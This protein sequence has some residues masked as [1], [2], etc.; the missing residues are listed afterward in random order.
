M[1]LIWAKQDSSPFQLYCIW[2]C[3]TDLQHTEVRSKP[4]IN[5][6]LICKNVLSPRP[7]LCHAYVEQYLTPREFPL[8]NLNYFQGKGSTT[9]D[10]KAESTPKVCCLSWAFVFH[11]YMQMFK[12][13][14]TRSISLNIFSCDNKETL[15]QSMGHKGPLHE[16]S[17]MIK[18]KG[19]KKKSMALFIKNIEHVQLYW[20]TSGGKLWLTWLT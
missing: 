8:K 12:T 5:G 10:W 2:S 19:K 6:F 7:V 11:F 16:F 4:I 20:S 18:T 17:F 3:I 13:D 1:E 9:H 14:M 15:L